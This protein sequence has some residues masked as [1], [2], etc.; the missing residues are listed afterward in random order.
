MSYPSWPQSLPQEFMGDGFSNGGAQP[1]NRQQME[2][3]LDRVTRISSVTVRNNSY[4]IVCDEKQLAD[5]WS[6]YENAANGGADFILAPML[7]GNK[8]SMHVCRF[9]SY[10]AQSRHGIK[11]KVSFSLE[12]DQ[13]HIVWS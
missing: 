1:V 10:P 5:F 7:T 6:F 2:S 4:S 12:T 3:G 8:V 9:S 11:W 13:Q